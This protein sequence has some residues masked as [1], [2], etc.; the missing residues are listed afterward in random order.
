[1]N[2]YSLNATTNESLGIIFREKEVLHHSKG[3]LNQDN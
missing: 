3:K 1:M 2:N